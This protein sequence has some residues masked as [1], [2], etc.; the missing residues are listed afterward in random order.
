MDAVPPGWKS[1]LSWIAQIE[2]GR[3]AMALA[4]M[5]GGKTEDRA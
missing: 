4:E 2:T 5:D 3:R 1:I